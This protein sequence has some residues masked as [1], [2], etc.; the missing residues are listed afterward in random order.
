MSRRSSSHLPC[1]GIPRWQG[2]SPDGAAA[3][4][5]DGGKATPAHGSATSAW[6]E[7]RSPGQARGPRH[8]L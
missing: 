1:C 3:P 6:A 8:L 2:S 7:Q 5:P 4:C